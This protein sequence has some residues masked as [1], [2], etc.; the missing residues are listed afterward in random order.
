MTT[1]PVTLKLLPRRSAKPKGGT[2][3]ATMAVILA[4]ILAATL[5]QTHAHADQVPLLP[6]EDNPE[7]ADSQFKLPTIKSPSWEFLEW[8]AVTEDWRFTPCYWKK[9]R[10]SAF[11]GAAVGAVIFAVRRDQ[12]KLQYS[13]LRGAIVGAVGGAGGGHYAAYAGCK[14]HKG[15]IWQGLG[16]GCMAL[17]WAVGGLWFTAGMFQ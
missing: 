9:V 14:Y 10:P 7:V 8:K 12:E 4:C 6:T 5:S 15:P 11:I 16:G 1:R 17:I 13:L 2:G 3:K